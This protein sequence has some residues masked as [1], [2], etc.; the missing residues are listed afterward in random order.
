MNFVHKIFP[1]WLVL[2]VRFILEPKGYKL[3]RKAVL[4][5]Y[6]KSDLLKDPV[7]REGIRFLKSHKFTTF[8]FKWA[9]KY[10]NLLPEVYF[11]ETHGMFYV[12]YCGHK[13]YYP[14][15]YSRMRAIWA[16]RSILKEQDPQSSHLYLTSDFYVE[17]DS[18]VV[19]AGV[20]EGNFALSII[21][22]VKRLY[23]IECDPTWVETLKV[24][25]A[26]WK[27]KVVFVEKYLSDMDDNQFVTIDYLVKAIEGEK[28]FVKMDVEGFEKQSL[29]GMKQ[30]LTV[31][32]NIKLDICTYHFED[33][34]VQIGS[35]MDNYGCKYHV[36]DGYVLFSQQNETPTFRK[37]LIRAEK[38]H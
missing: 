27:E 20:A 25:F 37:T 5:L 30:L 29:A 21:D 2:F 34:L 8:P 7:I 23:L 4:K 32:T 36:S 11:D 9:L 17:P 10:D 14:K 35:I 15:G 13:L 24:T 1:T 12:E 26:P 22:K 16:T 28:Y 19:D 31:A 18:I 33:D 38:L 6:E 3:R